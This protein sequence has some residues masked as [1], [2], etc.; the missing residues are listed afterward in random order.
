MCRAKADKRALV[1]VGRLPQGVVVVD[2]TG[3][4]PGRGAYVCRRRA[5]WQDRHVVARLGHALKTTL[6]A[7][8]RARLA[9]FG[10]RLAADDESPGDVMG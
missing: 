10:A 6:S 9:T 3:K 1:R 4:G 2:E 7:D 5:C 8:D